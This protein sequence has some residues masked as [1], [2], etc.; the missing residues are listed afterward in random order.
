ME[1]NWLNLIVWTMGAGVIAVVMRGNLWRAWLCLHPTSIAIEADAPAGQIKLPK[2][3]ERADAELRALGFV[4]L[5]SHVEQPRF[6]PEMLSYDYA[7]PGDQCFAT[8]YV[9]TNGEAKLYFLTPTERGGFVI[10][11]NH[12]RPAREIKGHYLSG[13]LES[14]PAPRVFTAHL[15]R[16]S[17]VGTPEGE[18][19]Q[20]GR[21]AAAKAWFAGPGKLEVRQ[22][23][24][25]GLLWTVGTV[26]MVAAAIFGQRS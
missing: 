19:T 13:A 12:R 6:G 16:V 14:L 4:S 25:L 22:Q 21:I 3:L 10:T 18:F 17:E 7:H 24:A 8:L 23:N 5:G 2:E 15:R 1:I 9:S 26:G 11:A 20:A